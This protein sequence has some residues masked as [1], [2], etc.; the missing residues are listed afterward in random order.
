MG[1]DTD[2]SRGA[3]LK[4]S[5]LVEEALDVLLKTFVEKYHIDIELTES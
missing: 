4:Q 2:F 5:Q 1:V 3:F